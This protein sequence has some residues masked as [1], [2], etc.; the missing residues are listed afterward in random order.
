[1]PQT[2]TSHSLNNVSLGHLTRLPDY[3]AIN[4]RLAGKLVHLIERDEHL[5]YKDINVQFLGK[6][7]RINEW[8]VT[9]SSWT[10]KLMP[11]KTSSGKISFGLNTKYLNQ[12]PIYIP[13]E[14]I[15]MLSRANPANIIR[16]RDQNKAIEKI[17]R[18]YN[19]EIS[20]NNKIDVK[21]LVQ[22]YLART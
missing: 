17:V 7:E 10:D 6:L 3:K 20:V 16:V 9:L 2:N 21:K 19:C 15:R 22:D 18:D 14:Q 5:E 8:G 1:M 4:R 13:Q 11:Y 12:R